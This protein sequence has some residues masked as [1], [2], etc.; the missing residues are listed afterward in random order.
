MK[1][2]SNYDTLI[3]TLAL[4]TVSEKSIQKS[5]EA[6]SDLIGK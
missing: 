6:T 5:A 4:K 1:N 3:R 2:F